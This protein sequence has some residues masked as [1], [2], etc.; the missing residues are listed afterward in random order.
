MEKILYIH[1]ANVKQNNVP[2]AIAIIQ[3]IVLILLPPI[4]FEFYHLT[5]PTLYRQN[6]K[7]LEDNYFFA[8]CIHE[9][10]HLLLLFYSL[11]IL[12]FI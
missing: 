12:L 9:K 1:H 5:T 2:N 4:L 6:E 7:Y 8:I 10:F 3:S 11:L